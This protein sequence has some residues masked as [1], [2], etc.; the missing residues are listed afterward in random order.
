LQLPQDLPVSLPSKLVEQRPDV[1][2][3]EAQMHAASAL[4]GVAVAAQLPQFSL[5]A[6]AG[7]VS[8]L[9]SQFFA[10]PGTAFWTVAGNM[11]QTVLD[12]G[13]LLH[14]K[15][16]ADVAFHQTARDVSQ[17]GDHRLAE[18]RRRAARSAIRCRRTES[19][20][21]G[22]ARRLQKPRDRAPATAAGCD[23]LSRF[24]YCREHL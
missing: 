5:T 8:N 4:I 21:R 22:R 7:T 3:A 23:Q 12:A 15:R 9:I 24:A 6:N 2:S 19:S 20:L 1:R 17:H 11:A 16:A 10:T 13:T 14:K 18:C